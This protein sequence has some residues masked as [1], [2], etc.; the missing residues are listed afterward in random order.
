[1]VSQTSTLEVV[2]RGHQAQVVEQPTNVRLGSKADIT[3]VPRHVRFTPETGHRVSALACLLK[4]RA[5]L[6]KKALI[7]LFSF[8]II[9]SLNCSCDQHR[10]KDRSYYQRHHSHSPSY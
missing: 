1:M 2:G 8:P 9:T 6:N 3:L 10:K 5:D 7:N 4:Q